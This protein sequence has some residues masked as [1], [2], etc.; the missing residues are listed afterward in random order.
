M[1]TVEIKKCNE[2]WHGRGEMLDALGCLDTDGYRYVDTTYLSIF[3]E[4]WPS[5]LS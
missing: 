5:G 3:L 1:Y 2:N 4:C